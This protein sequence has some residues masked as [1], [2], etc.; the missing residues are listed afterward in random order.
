MHASN[1]DPRGATLAALVRRSPVSCP[2]GT[3]ISDA[4]DTMRREDIGA[5]VIAGPD[6]VPEGILTLKDVLGRI[7][8]PGNR[9]DAP[10]ES[11]MSGDLVTL[12]AQASA[13]DAALAMMVRGIHHVVVVDG[14]RLAGV[15]SDRD[16]SRRL[17]AD[18]R[19]A[20]RMMREARSEEDLRAFGAAIHDIAHGMLAQDAGAA[21]VTLLVTA[22]NDALTRLLVARELA[23]E[24]A[25]PI[26]LCWIAM[27]SEGRYEQTLVTDQDNGIVFHCPDRPAGEVRAALMPAARRIN[28]ALA[29]AGFSLCRGGIMAS[30]PECCMSL[31]EWQH[32]FADWID[33]GDPKAL[34][35]ATIFFDFRP[36]AGAVRLAAELR[37]WLGA[38]AAG[39]GRFL[40]QMTGNALE[41]QPPLGLFRDF[42]LT[43]SGDHPHTLDLKVNGITPF[44]D[45][46]R[47]YALKAGIARTGT[48]ERL[49][50]AGAALAFD[51]ATIEGWIDAFLFIQSLRLR[52]HFAL[53]RRGSAIHNHIDPRSLSEIERRILLE[54]MRQARSLQSRLA[55][56]HCL[57]PGVGA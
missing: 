39:S 37:E 13:Y 33:V 27:G 26:E 56:D 36:V 5:M 32:R 40:A 43:G 34:L 28:E 29:A 16:V 42:I 22:M 20:S 23:P 47:I 8:Q 45:A 38:Y 3:P 11:V 12:P 14:G 18:L 30:N 41:N 25:A 53:G 46:A 21:P 1:T 50:G 54:S 48:V 19:Q 10:I 24:A 15:V 31:P 44:V 51:P 55:G 4:L 9:W 2:A 7:A 17:G 57:G 6:R 35:N 49:R 52:H